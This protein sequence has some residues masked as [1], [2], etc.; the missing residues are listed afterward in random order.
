LVQWRTALGLAVFV[1]DLILGVYAKP[2]NRH[3]YW[4]GAA[5]M[6]AALLLN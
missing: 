4:L 3:V 6:A 5:I 2:Q 1:V